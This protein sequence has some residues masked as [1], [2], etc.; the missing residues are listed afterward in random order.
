MDTLLGSF[1]G[2]PVPGVSDYVMKLADA[3][4]GTQQINDQKHGLPSGKTPAEV[5]AEHDAWREAIK[6]KA[7]DYNKDYKNRYTDDKYTQY[8]GNK[9]ETNATFYYLPG[10]TTSNDD[11]YDEYAFTG[12]MQQIDV[13]KLHRGKHEY[14]KVT[15]TANGQSVIIKINDHGPY[16]R[17]V[18]DRYI[19]KNGKEVVEKVT[20]K[21]PTKALDLSVAAYAAITHED[22]VGKLRVK[23]EFLSKTDGQTQYEEQLR[24]TDKNENMKRAGSVN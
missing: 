18:T 15:N 4:S 16:T 1:T 5:K 17:I 11:E 14:A 21:D 19:G 3:K 20:M 2:V 8:D 13:G 22:K 6:K 23:I 10:N 24:K 7:F 9:M 12:A